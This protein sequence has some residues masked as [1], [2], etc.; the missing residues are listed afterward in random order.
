[1]P[2]SGEASFFSLPSF[3][4]HLWCL[5]RELRSPSLSSLRPLQAYVIGFYEKVRWLSLAAISRPLVAWTSRRL[6]PSI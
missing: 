6:P 1:M 5:E 2:R 4:P 3:L